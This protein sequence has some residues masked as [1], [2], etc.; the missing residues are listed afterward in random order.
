MRY[1]TKRFDERRFLARHRAY[2]EQLDR[3]GELDAV[4]EVV[5][6]TRE[7]LTALQV[8]PIASAELMQAMLARRG[9]RSIDADGRRAEDLQLRCRACKSWRECRRWVAGEGQDGD[10]RLFC[11]NAEDFEE[12]GIP[13]K[14]RQPSG[15]RR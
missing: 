3:E 4:L 2:I 9:F 10:Y 7:Q 11:P 1:A 6:L 13:T 5:G 12:V 15:G 14:V 8:S